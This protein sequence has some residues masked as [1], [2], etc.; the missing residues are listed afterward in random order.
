IQG[1][2]SYWVSN[3]RIPQQAATSVLPALPAIEVS[4]ELIPA[5]VREWSKVVPSGVILGMILLAALGICSTVIM[6]TRSE[7]RGSISQ[8]QQITSDITVK[9]RANTALQLDIH[10]MN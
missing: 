7:L 6:R 1:G 2:T 9:G 5:T 3:R 10:P 4:R 8:Y